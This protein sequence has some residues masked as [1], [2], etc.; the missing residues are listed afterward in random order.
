M[1]TQ[2]IAAESVIYRTR[3][4]YQNNQLKKGRCSCFWGGRNWCRWETLAIF[5]PNIVEL[6]GSTDWHIFLAPVER[7]HLKGKHGRGA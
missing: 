1:R 2:E 3:D 6:H 7:K 4:K 5:K